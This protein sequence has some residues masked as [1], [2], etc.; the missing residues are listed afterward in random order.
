MA[1]VPPVRRLTVAIGAPRYL[2]GVM[3]IRAV[4]AVAVAIWVA[5]AAA[6]AE[7]SGPPRVI[8]G[9]TLEVAGRRFR[10]V[11]IDAPDPAQTC[12]IRGR[13]YGC[14][15]VSRTALMDLVAG[16]EVRCVPKKGTAFANC[17]AGGYDLSEGMVHAG[18]ALAMPRA[19]T[20]YARIERRA[21]KAQ[22][23]LW[24]G[25]FDMPW[26]W[27]RYTKGP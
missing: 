15:E 3:N 20:K 8:D 2:N 22:R 27:R 25:K 13:R 16:V 21:E 1:R 11:G 14:G 9:E 5:P 10:L 26:V 24:Q 6:R 17:Y 19:G 23:G 12:E 4:F 7:V 18:W